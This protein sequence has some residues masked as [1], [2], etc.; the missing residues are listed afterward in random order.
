MV[1]QQDVVLG[2]EVFDYVVVVVCGMYDL[3]GV[4]MVDDQIVVWIVVQVVVFGIVFDVVVLIVVGQFQF[5]CVLG[6]GDVFD[7][8]GQGKVCYGNYIVDVV[9]WLFDDLCV[10]V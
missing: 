6:C 3:V 10:F 1:F 2:G 8:G 5:V 4:V 9:L 7:I